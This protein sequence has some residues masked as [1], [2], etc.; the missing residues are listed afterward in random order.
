MDTGYFLVYGSSAAERR[1][2]M[3]HIDALNQAF[4]A[5]HL[6]F[7]ADKN[8]DDD[9]S[10][11]AR[12]G[13]LQGICCTEVVRRHDDSFLIIFFVGRKVAQTPLFQ[14][15]TSDAAPADA[16]LYLQSNSPDPLV[17]MAAMAAIPNF[18][19]DSSFHADGL[20]PTLLDLAGRAR[21]GLIM[22][23]SA[24]GCDAYCKRDG[25]EFENF[26]L[27]F[28]SAT[29]LLDDGAATSSW[30]AAVLF[31]QHAIAHSTPLGVFRPSEMA[32]EARENAW[33]AL[34]P[35]QSRTHPRSK[36]QSSLPPPPPPPSPSPPLSIE[37]ME[38]RPSPP[39]RM[40]DILVTPAMLIG[41][42]MATD[43]LGVADA[44]R[45]LNFLDTRRLKSVNLPSIWSEPASPNMKGHGK[46]WYASPL[47]GGPT[48]VC[49]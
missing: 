11:A 32:P 48:A 12:V 15:L 33:P 4:S 20:R 14:Y 9:S 27:R 6:F 34:A 31:A 25:R 1:A 42:A 8:N 41:V 39:S 40:T 36:P 35:S 45:P 38:T 37:E 24:I 28:H 3:A 2:R 18:D 21:M 47:R 46:I 5:G 26:Y 10:A 22:I 49:G 44:I 23:E 43:I 17:N 30:H 13:E 19:F 16:R 7:A 29:R